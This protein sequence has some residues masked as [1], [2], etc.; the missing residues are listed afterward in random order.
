MAEDK[1]GNIWFGTEHGNMTK[2]EAMGG[3]WRYDGNSFKNFITK[4]G[5][6]NMSVFSIVEDRA[7]NIWVGTRNTGLYRYDGKT[8]TSFSE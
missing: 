2:R 5:L 7:G 4:D 6:G 3:V 1:W 8:F